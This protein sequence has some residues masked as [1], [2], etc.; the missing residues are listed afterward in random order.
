MGLPPV[1]PLREKF[2][3]MYVSP[4]PVDVNA[5][6]YRVGDL[7]F[8]TFLDAEQCLVRVRGFV[9]RVFPAPARDVGEARY[10]VSITSPTAAPPYE[11][12]AAFV[13]GRD[14]LEL[15]L[16]PLPRPRRSR[17]WRPEAGS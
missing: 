7:V 5:A 4:H 1:S 15:R 3:L 6:S 9:T 8:L 13:V 16:P 12:G 10:E 11:R 2:N 14:V 17:A